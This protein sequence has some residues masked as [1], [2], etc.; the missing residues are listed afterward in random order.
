ML[1]LFL[2]LQ[3]LFLFNLGFSLSELRD[4]DVCFSGL[5]EGKV[6][7]KNETVPAILNPD[8]LK[9]TTELLD[10]TRSRLPDLPT[11]LKEYCSYAESLS[12]HFLAKIT[13]QKNLTRFDAYLK[14]IELFTTHYSKYCIH[15]THSSFFNIEDS[16][17]PFDSIQ[18]ASLKCPSIFWEI[19]FVLAE[20]FHD[21]DVGALVKLLNSVKTKI[22]S[23][24]VRACS[25]QSFYC[26]TLARI[27]RPLISNL[28]YTHASASAIVYLVRQGFT[29]Y[30]AS[31][32]I[33]S[34]QQTFSACSNI[35][36]IASMEMDHLI[37]QFSD[38]TSRRSKVMIIKAIAHEHQHCVER[39]KA[40]ELCQ[41]RSEFIS[42]ELTKILEA[43]HDQK[44]IVMDIA[45][46]MAIIRSMCQSP[47]YSCLLYT[48]PSPRDQA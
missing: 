39:A 5:E 34:E 31:C 32:A 3:T 7:G 1:Q 25:E 30:V 16:S 42:N 11:G 6:L 14:L 26:L 17:I 4:I 9:A 15:S 45:K 40:S 24:N 36:H 22:E 12:R 47:L 38:L 20:S 19:S 33:H 21:K 29:E 13:P 18:K 8:I 43:E 44:Q 48:S 35:L 41:K 2:S 27:F 23:A 28:Q 10:A 46:E 37:S